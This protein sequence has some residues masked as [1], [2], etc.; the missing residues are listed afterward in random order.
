MALAFASALS[1]PSLACANSA[2]AAS[3]CPINQA[4]QAK[5]Q[6][7]INTLMLKRDSVLALQCCQLNVVM[8]CAFSLGPVPTSASETFSLRPGT[9]IMVSSV[10]WTA[11]KVSSPAEVSFSQLPCSESVRSPIAPGCVTI[12]S[13][14]KNACKDSHE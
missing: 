3:T 13:N 9:P 12:T 11:C 7:Q 5:Q 10:R 6:S 14:V 4:K 2:L 1:A 8:L